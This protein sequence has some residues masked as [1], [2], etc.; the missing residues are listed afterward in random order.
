MVKSELKN[1]GT[2]RT[3][4][5]KEEGGGIRGIPPRPEKQKGG[6]EWD[7]FLSG[8]A[9]GGAGEH[10]GDGGL[11]LLSQAQ[12]PVLVKVLLAASDRNQ[13]EVV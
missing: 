3:S 13:S 10:L 8:P 5:G 12:P 4:G 6:W 11:L 1:K 9:L 7:A 2:E